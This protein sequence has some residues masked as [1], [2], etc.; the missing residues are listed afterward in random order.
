MFAK[1][2]A[3]ALVLSTVIAAAPT[4]TTA[5]RSDPVLV[6]PAKSWTISNL[7]RYC[8]DGNTGCDYNF[9][10][11]ADC[12]T[13]RCTII[14]MPGSNAAIE[15]WSNQSCTN[16]S[17]LT[18]SWGYIA[19]PAPAYA[20]ITVVKGKQLAWFGVPDVNGA[21]VTPSNPFGS[22]QYGTLPDSPVYTY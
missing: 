21:K 16:G 15:S 3:I 18:I 17:N 5:P 7:T 13:E 6:S 2:A 20:V 14:R 12:A 11:T 10:V 9:A 8:N 22:G 4:S 19:E 1:T